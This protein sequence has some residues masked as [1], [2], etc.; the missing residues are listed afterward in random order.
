MKLRDVLKATV[1]R[2]VARCAPLETQHAT[3]APEHATTSATPVQHPAADPRASCRLRA[4]ADATGAQLR[5]CIAARDDA[6]PHNPGATARPFRLPRGQADACHAQTWT[7]DE[8][9]TFLRRR[10]AFLGRGLREVDAEDLAERLHLRDLNLDDR[11]LCLECRNLDALASC[12]W[13][14]QSAFIAGVPPVVPTEFVMQLQR[15]PAFRVV[16]EETG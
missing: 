8:A 12:A 11:R 2:Q 14:C 13:V 4:T 16:D 3:F 9:S 1:E 10:A 15:C 7:D 6:L 5:R